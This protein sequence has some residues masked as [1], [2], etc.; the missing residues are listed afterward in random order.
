MQKERGIKPKKHKW[1]TVLLFNSP[2]PCPTHPQAA[3]ILSW[4]I[5]RSLCTEHDILCYGIS[6]WHLGSAVLTMLTPSFLCTC[7]QAE[8]GTW[9]SA[10]LRVSTAQQH[11]KHHCAINSILIL[12][13]KHG[14]VPSTKKK[15][16]SIPGKTRTRVYLMKVSNFLWG[17]KSITGLALAVKVSAICF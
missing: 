11:P 13:P 10:C 3:L 1:C 12:H 7:S 2:R 6:L 16:N 15:N 8:H 5:P 17:Q 14:T 4:P 9:R